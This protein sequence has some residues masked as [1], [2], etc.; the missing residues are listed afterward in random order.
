MCRSCSWSPASWSSSGC[1]A[2]AC[3]TSFSL[4]CWPR[5]PKPKPCRHGP[6]VT[7]SPWRIRTSTCARSKLCSSGC[8]SMASPSAGSKT[9]APSATPCT[10]ASGP[11]LRGRRKVAELDPA[12]R[13]LRTIRD[14]E[15][16]DDALH[17]HFDGADADEEALR[18]LRVGLAL[19]DEAQNV[20]FALCELVAVLREL[21][22]GWCLVRQPTDELRGELRIERRFAAQHLANR[23][24]HL[25]STGVFEDV[26]SRANPHRLEQVI[27]IFGKGHDQDADARHLFF[28]RARR[29]ETVDVGHTDVHQHQVR[30]QL[31]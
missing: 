20:E 18:D 8:V 21:I 23:G 2:S 29:D 5:C 30:L 26:P 19:G 24:H 22:L 12:H 17:V 7:A 4:T 25:A 28:D 27:R 15:L 11:C 3:R 9:S 1:L 10:G 6:F 16:V 13:G 14:A 31:A